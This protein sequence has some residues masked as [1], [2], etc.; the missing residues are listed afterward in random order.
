MDLRHNQLPWS[1]QIW[2]KINADLAQ[3]LAQS[4]R[5]R[6]PFEVFHVPSSQQ[7][8]MADRS[9]P[10]DGMKFSDT[11]TTPIIELA[12]PFALS[13]SQVHNEGDNFY[14]LDRIIAAAYDIGVVED[15]LIINAN[16]NALAMSNPS[17]FVSGARSLWDGI[18]YSNRVYPADPFPVVRIFNNKLPPSNSI[19]VGLELYN[20]VIEA[21]KNLREMKRYEPYALI[22]S[23]DLEGE[24]QSTVRGTNSL[25]TPIERLKPLA[26]AGIHTTP[27][28]PDKTALLV[29]VA[30]SWIDIAQ[31]MEPSVQFLN[32]DGQGNYHMRL[33]E[34]FAFRM[35]DRSARCMI[36]MI[37][38]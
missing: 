16:L 38:V 22:L 37:K 24:I 31:A 32:I 18:Y 7:S 30:R 28:L 23:N 15:E 19:P 11:E 26:T 3:A 5:V 29:S 10:I 36:K 21:R 14:S 2:A 6:A 4:R 34:R 12:V 17:V 27:V 1:D 33:V 20:A 9:D 8:V 35:K 13:Q 25:N